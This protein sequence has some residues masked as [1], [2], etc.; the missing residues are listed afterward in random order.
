MCWL[1]LIL[2]AVMSVA[3]AVLIL[4]FFLGRGAQR[5]EVA[6]LG[7]TETMIVGVALLCI[8]PLLF[9]LGL[10]DVICRRLGLS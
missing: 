10:T 9:I 5:P 8:G 1:P 6:A 2:G 3:G 7:R 4:R